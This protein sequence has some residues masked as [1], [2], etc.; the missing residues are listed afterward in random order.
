MAGIKRTAR[1]LGRELGESETKKNRALEI[2][3]NGEEKAGETSSDSESI[4]STSSTPVNV[5]IKE[6]DTKRTHRARLTIPKEGLV[7]PR[8]I[9]TKSARRKELDAI[10]ADA[11]IDER[12]R[13]DIVNFINDLFKEI[14]MDLYDTTL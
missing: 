3:S 8:P 11:R 10:M 14:A 12:G 13:R 7:V 1:T 9:P 6:E 4:T 2:H 5:V